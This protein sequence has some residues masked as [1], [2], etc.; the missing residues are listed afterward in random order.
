MAAD[1]DVERHSPRVSGHHQ[2]SGRKDVLS[3][4]MMR[5]VAVTVEERMKKLSMATDVLS[6]N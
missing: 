6:M 5:Y 2:Q 1:T 3:A 4:S